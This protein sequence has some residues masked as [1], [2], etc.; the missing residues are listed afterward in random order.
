MLLSLSCPQ[1]WVISHD[2]VGFFIK[3]HLIPTRA[4]IKWQGSEIK[5][6]WA[7]LKIVV[8]YIRD[9]ENRPDYCKY[10]QYL[11]ENKVTFIRYD[12]NKKK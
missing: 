3:N 7:K 12:S 6:L 2:R 10:F 11:G 5:M 1:L 4:F 9:K 8:E